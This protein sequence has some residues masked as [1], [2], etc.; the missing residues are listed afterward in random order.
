MALRNNV[1]NGEIFRATCPFKRCHK[2]AQ[3]LI[4]L[5]SMDALPPPPE[6]TELVP[7]GGSRSSKMRRSTSTVGLKM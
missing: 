3:R 7:C 4:V 6:N 5:L 1:N 2:Q